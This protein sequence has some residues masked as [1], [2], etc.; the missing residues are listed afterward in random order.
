M[1][2]LIANSYKPYS[3][4]R[5][6]PGSNLKEVNQYIYNAAKNVAPDYPIEIETFDSMML[7]QYQRE[8]QTIDYVTGFSIVSI[9]LAL[10][11]ILGLI[12]FES[13][14]KQKE[15]GIRKVFGATEQSLLLRFT[16]HYLLLVSCCFLIAIPIAT[17]LVNNWNSNFTNT[18]PLYWWQFV[19][20]FLIVA[21]LTLL[22]V[23]LQTRKTI[24]TD[25]IDTLRN[26]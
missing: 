22:I 1:V 12:A 15:V 10:M 7:R 14:Y 16:T 6:R 8:Y 11:G 23:V 26:E 13:Q 21:L 2:L 18:P 5:I 19:L 3:F 24:V 20:A 17:T 25:P 9:I 4:I